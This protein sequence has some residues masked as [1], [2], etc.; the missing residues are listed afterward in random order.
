VLAIAPMSA[1][2]AFL[3]NIDRVES[4]TAG[5]W[6]GLG[7]MWLWAAAALA[8]ALWLIGRRDVTPR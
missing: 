4:L 7:V 1:G 8:L 2:L 6:R 3:R 5:E